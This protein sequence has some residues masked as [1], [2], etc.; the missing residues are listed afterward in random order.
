MAATRA[1]VFRP[2]VKG[3]EYYGNEIESCVGG[4]A[5]TNLSRKHPPKIVLGADQLISRTD[6]REYK[7]L[8]V[9]MKIKHD[10][11]H[12]QLDLLHD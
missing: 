8:R 10:N 7:V 3:N 4:H 11:A 12:T 1:L 5:Q 2:L 9:I 6:N